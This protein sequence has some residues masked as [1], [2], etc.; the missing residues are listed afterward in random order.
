MSEVT[1]TE[2]TA[3][4]S[5]STPAPA[6]TGGTLDDSG[7]YNADAALDSAILARLE[8]AGLDASDE[9][10]PDEP[11][12]AEKTADDEAEPEKTAAPAA[13]ESDEDALAKELGI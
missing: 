1:S 3:A 5:E 12:K 4:T 6:D 11:V 13:A 2:T 8:D 10:A 9:P 7:H